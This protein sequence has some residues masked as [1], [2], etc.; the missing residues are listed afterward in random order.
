MKI[1]FLKDCE[2][3]QQWTQVLCQCCGPELMGYDLASFQKDEEVD[4]EEWH[5]EIDLSGLQYRVDY[6]IVEY[7]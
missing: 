1:K 5:K 7:P 6:D 2:A 4:P 3:P